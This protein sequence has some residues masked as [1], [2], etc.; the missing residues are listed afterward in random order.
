M[1]IGTLLLDI[2]E[3]KKMQRNK[4]LHFFI[5]LLLKK[6][7]YDNIIGNLIKKYLNY[8]KLSNRRKHKWLIITAV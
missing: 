2:C 5:F 6:S 4:S 8:K 3:S 7:F 1:S